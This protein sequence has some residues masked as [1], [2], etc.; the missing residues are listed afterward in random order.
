MFKMWVFVVVKWVGVYIGF[1]VGDMMFFDM[2]G[3]FI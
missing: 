2:F 3:V 1:K